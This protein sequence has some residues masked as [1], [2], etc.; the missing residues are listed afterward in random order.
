MSINDKLMFSNENYLQ[1]HESHAA[2]ADV[3]LYP[4]SY[5]QD[6]SFATSTTQ[7]NRKML[8]PDI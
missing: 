5:R 4:P 3:C 7:E 2:L 1:L 6:S 8:K